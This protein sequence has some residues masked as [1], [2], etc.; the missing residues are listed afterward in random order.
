[1][2]DSSHMEVLK[3]KAKAKHLSLLSSPRLTLTSFFTWKAPVLIWP[4]VSTWVW[5]KIGVSSKRFGGYVAWFL[6]PA[7]LETLLS[8][9]YGHSPLLRFQPSPPLPSILHYANPNRGPISSCRSG[10]VQRICFLISVQVLSLPVLPHSW[11]KKAPDPR[12]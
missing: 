10:G 11:R 8:S 6:L 3:I 5:Q 4:L 9:T 7:R 12:I 2:E 1:M